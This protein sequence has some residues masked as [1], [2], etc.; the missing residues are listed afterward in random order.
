MHVQKLT[1]VTPDQGIEMFAHVDLRVSES[2]RRRG[3]GFQ[4]FVSCE[5]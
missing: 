5:G 2:E 3:F 4:K 1:V